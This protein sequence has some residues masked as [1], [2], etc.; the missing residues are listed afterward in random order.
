MEPQN[1][2]VPYFFQINTNTTTG[3]AQR[4]KLSMTILE[5]VAES[6]TYAFSEK[7]TDLCLCEKTI[8]VMYFDN[9]F[10]HVFDIL[11]EKEELMKIYNQKY[12]NFYI[13]SESESESESDSY[14]DSYSEDSDIDIDIDI[15]IDSDGDGV[16]GCPD[17]WEA[18]FEEARK[19]I[20]DC[21][22]KLM[23]RDESDY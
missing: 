3:T 9:S 16:F 21:H 5:D 1:H 4:N 22:I 17:K 14:S 8:K 23:T 2:I 19:K 6:M 11:K 12:N 18:L 7:Q 13:E 10:W 20:Y 15:D